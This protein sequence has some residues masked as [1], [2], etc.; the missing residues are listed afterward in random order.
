M[1]LEGRK[2]IQIAWIYYEDT[3]QDKRKQHI[4]QLHKPQKGRPPK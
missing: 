4:K 2:Y 1:K 3:N